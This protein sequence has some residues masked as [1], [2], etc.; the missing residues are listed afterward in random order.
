MHTHTHILTHTQCD[1]CMYTHSHSHT[2]THTHTHT[3]LHLTCKGGLYEL[4]CGC[5]VSLETSEYDVPIG[6]QHLRLPQVLGRLT[7]QDVRGRTYKS[8]R[9]HSQGLSIM[10]LYIL[11]LCTAAS[12][13]WRGQHYSSWLL[14]CQCDNVNDDNNLF[15]T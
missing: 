4:E 13:T 15:F 14:D 6:Q 10:F 11:L 2:H 1:T 7:P 3:H 12:R 8:H 5:G 9:E